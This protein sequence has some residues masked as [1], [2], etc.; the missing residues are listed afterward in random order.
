MAVKKPTRKVAAK[1][2]APIAVRKT[3]AIQ[4]KYTK[5]E[6]LNEITENTS[7]SK[8]EVSAVLDEL[9]IIIERHIKKRA[10]G[11]FT[12]PGLLKIKSVVRPARPARKNVPNPFKP[13]ELMDIP[14]KPATTRV[15][16]LPLKKLKEFAL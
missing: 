11:E 14:R 1:K 7:I 4:K 5:T 2:A 6:I 15:K 13:G 10:V 3:P 9:G 8:K 12:L 16:V